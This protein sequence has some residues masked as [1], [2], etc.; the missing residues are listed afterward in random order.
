LDELLNLRDAYKFDTLT[1]VEDNALQKN[2]NYVNFD[3]SG[4][5]CGDGGEQ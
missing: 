1:S 4:A 2:I 3:V 5:F